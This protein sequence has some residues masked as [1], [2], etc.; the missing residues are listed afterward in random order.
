MWL[1]A[2]IGNHLYL[3]EGRKEN[4]IRKE[5]TKASTILIMFYSFK[6]FY[7]CKIFHIFYS[8]FHHHSSIKMP[9]MINELPKPMASLLVPGSIERASRL[10][11]HLSLQ[12]LYDV[13]LLLYPSLGSTTTSLKT[14][15]KSKPVFPTYFLTWG[16]LYFTAFWFSTP[17]CPKTPQ[18]WDGPNYPPAVQALLLFLSFPSS[19]SGSLFLLAPVHTT[20]ASSSLM[21]NQLPRPVLPSLCFPQLV[22][23]PQWLLKGCTYYLSSG[24]F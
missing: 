22:W 23:F 8:S 1:Q 17:G 6:Y 9:S 3:L 2:H 19:V 7:I 18:T 20:Q 4:V 12:P 11:S 15:C 24:L 10:L 21:Y 13:V 14:V 16:V 5:Y